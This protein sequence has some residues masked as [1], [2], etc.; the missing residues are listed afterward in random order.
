MRRLY[1]KLTI[2][3]GEYPGILSMKNYR[4]LNTELNKTSTVQTPRS[5][6]DDKEAKDVSQLMLEQFNAV[7]LL[8]IVMQTPD[9]PTRTGK[10]DG[11]K[12]KAATKDGKVSDDGDNSDDEKSE[13]GE[14]ELLAKAVA[15]GKQ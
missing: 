9:P 13:L 7:D 6:D 14:D 1:P 3:E 8:G 12:P 4:V 2:N 15:T 5:I 11:E 10:G